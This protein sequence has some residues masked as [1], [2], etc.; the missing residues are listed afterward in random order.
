MEQAT[1]WSH[2][3]VLEA[4]AGSAARARAF[5]VHHLVEHRLLYLVD[6]VRLVASELATNAIVHART[7]FTVILAG[8][9][10]S[11]L[12]TVRDGSPIAPAPPLAAPDGM[13]MAGRGL[14]IVNL[15]S[16][17]WGVAD[18]RGAA[19]SVWASFETRPRAVS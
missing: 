8:R 3:T 11:V 2:Q 18:Q 10:S 9:E 15:M 12:L 17:T 1:L 6:D 16:Q 5:V 4:E 19:K 7:A 13:R 14:L